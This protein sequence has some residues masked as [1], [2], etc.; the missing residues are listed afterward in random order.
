MDENEEDIQIAL[1][2]EKL[3]HEP[4]KGGDYQFVLDVASPEEKKNKNEPMVS[5]KS[6]TA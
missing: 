2:K 5:P 6:L 1:F 3:K 4:Q